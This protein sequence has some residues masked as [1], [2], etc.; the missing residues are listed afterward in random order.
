MSEEKVGPKGEPWHIEKNGPIWLIA[1]A[2]GTAVALVD[3]SQACAEAR[4]V[5]PCR[6]WD[7]AVAAVNALHAAGLTP[8][9]VAA[10]AKKYDLRALEEFIEVATYTSRCL[11][12]Y[13][14]DRQ[15]REVLARLRRET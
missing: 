6:W 3:A 4:G 15:G 7:H 1:S 13:W 14:G 2:N 5:W 10:L 12:P 8:E 11:E 9:Q